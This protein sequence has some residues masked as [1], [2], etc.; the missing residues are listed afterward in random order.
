VQLSVFKNDQ[1]IV[2]IDLGKEL[3]QNE[4]GPLSFF[5][6]RAKDCHV[7]IDDKAISRYL[8][9]I[10]FEKGEWSIEKNSPDGMLLINGEILSKKQIKNGDVLNCRLYHF[11]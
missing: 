10:V 5:L 1:K 3:N 2:D 7:Q 4:Q 6:G 11:T 8:A 9:K